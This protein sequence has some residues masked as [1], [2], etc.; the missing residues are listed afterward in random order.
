M[1]ARINDKYA[2]SGTKT[3]ISGA[4]VANIAAQAVGS[5][6][7][8]YQGSAA[9]QKAAQAGTQSAAMESAADLQAN[10]AKLQMGTGAMNLALGLIQYQKGAQHEKNAGE[11]SRGTARGNSDGYTYNNGNTNNAVTATGVAGDTVQNYE[12]NAEYRSK[13]AEIN[14]LEGR[15]ASLPAPQQAAAREQ[16]NQ[17]KDTLKQ[18]MAQDV[19]GIGRQAKSEQNIVAGRAKDGSFISIISGAQQAAMGYFNKKAADEMREAAQKLKT[20][21]AYRPPAVDSQLPQFNPYLTPNQA[22]TARQLQ[23]LKSGNV[24][25]T[26]STAEADDS[27]DD[28]PPGLSLG[29]PNNPNPFND[30]IGSGPSPGPMV[31]IAN[32]GGG[33][34]GGGNAP[35]GSTSPDKGEEEKRAQQIANRSAS[36]SYNNG[37][38]YAPGAMNNG[39]GP[40]QGPD[41][42]KLLAQFLPKEGDDKLKNG[43]LDFGGGRGP[44]G[45]APFSVLDKNADIFKRIHETYQEK[46]THGNVGNN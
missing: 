20:A 4:Q 32:Q 37:G 42:S 28:A 12:M 15:I 5:A 45:D 30:N 44:A 43:I 35:G 1:G 9:T 6:A 13:I 25:P 18:R 40:T 17:L 7:V 23:G 33:P 29:Q 24:T 2:C 36:D 46:Q 19:Q 10:S 16:V 8:Q 21:E 11:I 3:L 14:Q 34:S 26:T 31:P 41:L 27:K 38:A 39:G 22:Q